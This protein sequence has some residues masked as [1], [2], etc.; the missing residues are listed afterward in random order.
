MVQASSNRPQRAWYASMS[1]A[2]ALGLGFFVLVSVAGVLGVGLVVGYQNTVDLLAQKA[3]LIINSQREHTTRFFDAAS[4]Q[5]EFIAGRIAAGEVEPGVS[6]EFT[7]LLTGAVSATPQIIRIQ[8]IDVNGRLAGVERQ[9]DQTAPI[10]QRVGDDL[11]LAKLTD[12]AKTRLKPFWGQLLWRGAYK[13]AVL[14]YQYPVVK[15]GKLAG[16][17]SAWVSIN[18]MSDFLSTLDTDF[19]ANTFILHGRDKV[20]A[21]P[22]MAFGYAG[23]HRGQPIPKQATFAD[24]VVA[25]MWKEPEQSTFAQQFISGPDVR[26]AAYGNLEY[27][28][29]FKELSGYSD[30]PLYIGTYFE[31]HDMTSEAGR[32]KWAIIICLAMSLL[33]AAAAAYIGRQISKP[34]K[35]LAEGAKNVHAF[36]LT[37]VQPI[38]R[39]FFRELDDAAQSFNVMLD[40]LR[41]FE[42]YVPKGL[43]RRL[44]EIT[45]GGEVES[46]YREVAVMFTDIVG[47]TTMSE[48][49]TAPATAEFLND[50]FAVISNCVQDEGGSVDKFIGDS[51][52]AIW[53]GIERQP[54]LA[55]RAC[56]CALQI[57]RSVA[58][59]NQKRQEHTAGAARLR[60]RIGIHLGRVVVG[61]IG[62]AGRVNY[63]VVGDAVNVAQRLEEAGKK[64]GNA[65]AD[66]N[67]LV[68][69]AVRD[70]LAKDF[71]LRHLGLKALRGRAEQ[72]EI[73]VLE[74]E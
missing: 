2:L 27:I 14:N 57:A 54:D 33:S 73:Y 37:K 50:H 71:D 41:W 26:F 65:K 55:D 52:M 72:V 22:L 15:S 6:E 23:L 17:M 66:V 36:E 42:R 32:L 43:V 47:F 16:V 64:L 4:N 3:G 46:S 12:A 63:T 7:S 70:G 67:I 29:L 74:G 49:L 9:R 8:F 19:G 5:V 51:V 61:N 10:F 34:V 38:P 20:L 13:Q 25:A 31:A 11:D 45:P 35:R 44:M 68:S 59:F 56:R 39:S 40:G 58:E 21:H 30:K 69:G 18:E 60:L 24:P 62:S 1:V 28:I 53:G 48:H